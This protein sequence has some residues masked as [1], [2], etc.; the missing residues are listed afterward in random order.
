MATKKKTVTKKKTTKGQK[1][2]VR[3]YSAGVHFGTLVSRNG[4]EV[5]LDGARRI[6]RWRGANTLS[7][8]A[9]KGL[10]AANSAIACAVDGHV[11]TEAIEILPCSAEA[12]K[13]I[14]GANAW[15]P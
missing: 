4:K 13:Q 10:D 1:V 9:T 11:L 8:I 5:V 3:T 6:W 14:E 12:A 7:E 15:K 2:I